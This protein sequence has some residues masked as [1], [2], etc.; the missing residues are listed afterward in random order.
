MDQ[1]LKIGT[2]GYSF[3]DWKGE[4]YPRTLSPV[5]MLSYYEQELGF[6]TVELNFTYYRQP[7]AR[8]MASMVRKTHRDFQFTVKANKG[9]THDL[10]NEDGRLQ[11][12]QDVFKEFLAGIEPLAVHRQLGA[13]LAQ[14]PV[15]F[16]NNA[17]NRDYLAQFKERMGQIP[18]IIEFRNNSWATAD[19]YQLLRNYG[20]G[21][22]SVDEPQ[23]PRLMPMITEVTGDIGYFRFHGRNPHWFKTTVAERY[24]YLYNKEELKEFIPKIRQV[25]A[26][27]K[28][29]YLFFN[30]CHG[31]KAVKNAL[32][33][34]ELMEIRPSVDKLF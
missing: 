13:V 29:T 34:M 25:F 23:L 14:F 12:N 4:I 32:Q 28:I 30:N 19:T 1:A 5:N 8:T 21:L 26:K 33:L 16:N 22:C 3:A 27:T 17:E 31:G 24:N 2:S 6:N 20:F 9:L 18:I 15:G 10:W 11:N 7:N